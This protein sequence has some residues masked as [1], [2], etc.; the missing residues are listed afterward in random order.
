MPEFLGHDGVHAR[1]DP[2]RRV[3]STTW[4]FSGKATLQVGGRQIAGQSSMKALG[5]LTDNQEIVWLERLALICAQRPV[6]QA[7]FSFRMRPSP[8][9]HP[10]RATRCR[11]AA[12][13][14]AEVR[15]WGE[16]NRF[17]RDNVVRIAMVFSEQQAESAWRPF[18]TTR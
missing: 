2:D 17:E 6:R 4:S 11:A 5:R 12:R 18:V 8:S 9:Q 1:T 15:N 16:Q 13:S 10:T 14:Y 3:P 7:D